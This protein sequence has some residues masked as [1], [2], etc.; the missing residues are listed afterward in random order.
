MSFR[1]A[2]R[3]LVGWGVMDSRGVGPTSRSF[4]VLLGNRHGPAKATLEDENG[5]VLRQAIGLA[6][7][8]YVPGAEAP[9]LPDLQT[10]DFSPGEFGC[11]AH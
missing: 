3:N 7:C 9:G 10:P 8:V 5:G 4:V 2:E 11:L 1:S 6:A